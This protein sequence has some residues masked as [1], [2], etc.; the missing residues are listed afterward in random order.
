MNEDSLFRD[1][2]HHPG[3]D[4]FADDL[5]SGRFVD[6]R[7]QD[8]GYIPVLCDKF[9]FESLVIVCGVVK[10][11]WSSHGSSDSG[12]LAGAPHA[13]GADRLFHRWTAVML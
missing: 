7:R 6:V 4:E 10:C 12:T 5:L 1:C 11:V 3:V 9:G 2:Y 13:I 8:P